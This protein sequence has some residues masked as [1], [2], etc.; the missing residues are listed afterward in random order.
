MLKITKI[1]RVF[2]LHNG[3]IYLNT[4]SNVHLP[5]LYSLNEMEEL[6][7]GHSSLEKLKR[8]KYLDKIGELVR[9]I[10]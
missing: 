6:R 10:I 4:N 1:H 3:S 9:N 8:E 5:Q 7:G 2:L